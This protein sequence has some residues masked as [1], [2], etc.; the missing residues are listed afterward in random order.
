[1]KRTNAPLYPEHPESE[2]KWRI[3]RARRFMKEEN[4]DALMLAANIDVFYTTGTRFVFVEME[5]PSIVAPQSATIVTPDDVVYCGR[6]G[7]FDSDSVGLDTSL[8]DNFEYYDE[9]TALADILKKYGVSRG[10]RIGTEYGQGGPCVGINPI[11][12]EALRKRVSDELGAQFVDATTA[13][14]KM[15]SV[16]SKLEIERMRKAVGAAARAMKRIFDIIEVGMNELD[17]AR[18]ASIFMLE[19]GADQVTH[20]QVMARG[21]GPP[22]LSCTALDRRI[23]KGYVSLDIGCKCMR[24]GSDINRGVMLGRQPTTDEKKLYE[25]RTGYN[26]VMERAIRPGLPMDEVLAKANEY[27]RE[28]GCEMQD[29]DGGHGIGL[30][31]HEKPCIMP[32]ASQPEFQNKDGKVL[33]ETGMMFTLEPAIKLLGTDLE[34]NVEDDIVVTETGVENMNSMLSRELR[35]KL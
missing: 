34:F 3:D 6:F 18:K 28:H 24:Y 23:E 1:V 7:P 4:L 14:W 10:D 12:F 8:V 19:E 25:C 15:R 31:I 29:M 17:V 22:F 26:E 33:F 35:V 21:E 16:K 13:I 32:S 5:K 20:N 11:T 9:E 2:H 30:D 27:V